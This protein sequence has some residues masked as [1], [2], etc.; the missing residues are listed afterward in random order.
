MYNTIIVLKANSWTDSFGNTYHT[1]QVRYIVNEEH[2]DSEGHLQSPSDIIMKSDKKVYGYGS[3][4]RQTAM[5]LLKKYMINI[6]LFDYHY[7]KKNKILLIECV[8]QV[9]K[10]DLFVFD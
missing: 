8:R 5:E 7:L 4:Y 6:D 10:K 9:K 3:A 1:V 2:V